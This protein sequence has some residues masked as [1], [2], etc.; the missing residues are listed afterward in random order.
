M[1]FVG[2]VHSSQSTSIPL[3]GQDNLAD[4]SQVNDTWETYSDIDYEL[5]LMLMYYLRKADEIQLL[6]FGQV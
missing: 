3:I 4:S 2:L 5:A 1:D 6:Q